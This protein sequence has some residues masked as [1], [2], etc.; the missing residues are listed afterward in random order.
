MNSYR[1]SIAEWIFKTL[2]RW[3]ISK[4]KPGS[5]G[6]TGSVGKTSTKEA[7]FVVLKNLRSV[8]ASQGNFNS[9]IGLALTVLGDWPENL[10]KL[11]SRHYYAKDNFFKKLSFGFKVIFISLR[12]LIISLKSGY[13]EI[14][15]LEYGADKPGDIKNLLDIV[16][17]QI[18]VITAIGVI[19]AHVEF[20]ASSQAVAREKG[21]LIE[22]LPANGFAVLNADD[23]NVFNL[24]DRTRA[25]ILTF[26]FSQQAEVRI[27][28]FEHRFENGHP[29]GVSFKLEYGGSF[30]PVRLDGSLSKA[31]AYASAAAACVGI[32]FGMN[33]IKI[34]E[35]LPNFQAPDH[36]MKILAGIKNSTII[37][38]SY[39]ASPLSMAL[40]LESVKSI[41]AER[42]VGI[43]GDMLE[44]GKYAM[45]AHE[46]V[47][48]VAAQIFDLLITVGPHGKLI[49]A[50]ARANGLAKKNV[51]EFD[52][53]DAVALKLPELI[54]QKDLILI[55]ASR[56]IKL[57]KLV[58]VIKQI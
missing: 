4:Y 11:L 50:A 44:I 15:V 58:E 6:I 30:V 51:V 29:T 49:A 26:G 38:D 19:P 8:R 20:Y 13:P 46:Q 55:K 14:L 56:A 32:I 28:N 42:K 23:E 3:T 40:A 2:A 41:S 25:H 18:G 24:K 47:G 57:D 33:L 37:D 21:R 48:V 7:I 43:L 5:I 16:R 45:E 31:V 1:S 10:I 36:R 52:S 35:A 9:P 54:R 17:L 22:N 34:A 12:N 53:A 27:T 39:N